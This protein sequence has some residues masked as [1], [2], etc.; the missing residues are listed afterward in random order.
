MQ[1][2]A[3]RAWPRR[4]AR[5]I[6][7]AGIGVVTAMAM[8]EARAFD[9]Q[10]DVTPAG[11]L[12]PALQLSQ[13]PRN[14]DSGDG[15]VSVR[16]SGRD[17]P[18]H[19]RVR[20]ET[21]GLR[22]AAVADA[23]RRLDADSIELRPRLDWDV[24]QLRAMHGTRRQ[25]LRI[26]LEAD[27]SALPQRVLDVRVHPLDEAVYFVREGRDRVDLGWIFAA[28]VNPRD[29]AVD[30]IVQ[31]ARAIEPAFDTGTDGDAD[32]RRVAAIWAALKRHGLRYAGA[33]PA[34]ARGPLLWSQRVRTP[35]ESWRDR[36]ANCID[37]S[38]LLASVLERIGIIPSLVLVPRHAFVAF[39]IGAGRDDVRYLETTLLDADRDASFDIALRA[40][41]ARWRA[42]APKL[43]G[44][45]R[46]DYARV[47]IG[48]ARAY[49]I[50]PLT[51]DADAAQPATSAPMTSAPT[52]S[53][54]GS[55]RQGVGEAPASRCLSHPLAD[56]GTSRCESDPARRLP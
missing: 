27:G 13:P 5:R 7:F 11:E 40:G 22:S 23:A 36:R 43:D 4:W 29:P 50:I 52:T 16:V 53:A 3:T 48:A 21:E 44:R 19:V 39:R 32:L 42:V 2:L 55:R 47:D 12:V 56:P 8:D 10:I 33:D 28:Y 45:H 1:W 54:S 9:W 20:V 38:V 41:F 6:A 34:V 49:G 26:V 15:L 31:Q 14:A 25:A 46:P 35:G 17:L 37:G 51:I 18:A 24:S 30:Q